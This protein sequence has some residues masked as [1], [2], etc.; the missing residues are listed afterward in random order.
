[1]GGNK[2]QD[3]GGRKKTHTPESPRY[4]DG[5]EMICPSSRAPHCADK[6]N[7]SLI[8]GQIKTEQCR[9]S[10]DPKVIHSII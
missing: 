5:I 9:S 10:S 1:M 8:E 6:P 4:T 7:L 2:S 3:G